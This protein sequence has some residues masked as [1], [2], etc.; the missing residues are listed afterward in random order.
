V[1]G[2]EERKESSIHCTGEVCLP[3]FYVT[4]VIPCHPTSILR[5]TGGRI[6]GSQ[7]QLNGEGYMVRRDDIST[8]RLSEGGDEG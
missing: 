5:R 3:P 4:V 6:E 1:Q 7:L 8:D 2:G